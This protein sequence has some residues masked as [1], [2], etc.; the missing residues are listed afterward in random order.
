[1]LRSGESVA[2]WQHATRGGMYTDA[3]TGLTQTRPDP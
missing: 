2:M 3:I 1:M